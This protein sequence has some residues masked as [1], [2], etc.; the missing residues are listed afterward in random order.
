[1]FYYSIG[2]AGVV[3]TVV[4][5]H[6]YQGPLAES[7]PSRFIIKQ[8]KTASGGTRWPWARR[9]MNLKNVK[10]GCVSEV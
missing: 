7:R 2:T 3:A 8:T 4:A 10:G 9:S 5:T 1:M 6:T